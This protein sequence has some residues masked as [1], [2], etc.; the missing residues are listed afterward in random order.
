MSQEPAGKGMQVRP[1]VDQE[2]A[3]RLHGLRRDRNLSQDIV[4]KAIG[5]SRSYLA[6]IE[7]GHDAPGRE[8]LKRLSDFYEV[9]L[10]WLDSGKESMKV[11]PTMEINEEEA[12]LLDAYRVLP[13]EESKPLL[14]MLL[15]RVKRLPN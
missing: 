2:R 11:S 1:P 3:K 9:S 10:D 12:F 5:K 7:G 8:V 13:R 4:A 6:G 14:E 15:S